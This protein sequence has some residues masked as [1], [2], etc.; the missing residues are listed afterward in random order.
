MPER[1]AVELH[2]HTSYSDGRG[3][4]EELLRHAADVGVTTIAITD[5]DTAEG[6]RAAVA[7]APAHGVT[8][9]PAIELTCRWDACRLPPGD[10]DIDM[11]GYF[12]DLASPALIRRER[13]ALA[14][15]HERTGLCCELLTRAG[16]PVALD[17]VFAA[18]PRY[19]GYS[20]VANVLVR[21]GLAA[22]W[23]AARELIM[24]QLAGVR[25]SRFTIDEMIAVVR[26]AGGVPVLAHPTV[27]RFNGA[28][29]ES[30][31]VAAL[32]EMGLGG[33]EVYHHALDDAAREHFLALARRH[34][35]A[36]TG[37]SDDHGWPAGYTR[38]GVEPVT[39]EMV[40]ELAARRSSHPT[41]GAAYPSSA[42]M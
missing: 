40:A 22:D 27:A 37:G 41:G 32:V 7:V 14:D 21:K 33:I 11:L 12:V 4:P 36:V 5:H 28:W 2:V 23:R 39:S 25:P 42:A 18:S 9:I 26:A 6:A 38:L 1:A 3:S 31:Q 8:L 30:A 20:Q 15:I 17:E 29:L 24:A 19:A 34:G 13:E 35:L 16:Y 10:E